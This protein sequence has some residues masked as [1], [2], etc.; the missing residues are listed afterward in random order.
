MSRL[1]SSPSPLPDLNIDPNSNLNVDLVPES[2]DYNP[3]Q[4]SHTT[5]SVSVNPK[6]VSSSGCDFCSDSDSNFHAYPL[7][8]HYP[9][10]HGDHEFHLG[11]LDVVTQYMDD[12]DSWGLEDN[13]NLDALSSYMELGSGFGVELGRDEVRADG[14]RVTG[15]DPELE[16]GSDL[17]IVEMGAGGDEPGSPRLWDSFIDNQMGLAN[18]NEEFEWEELDQ[19]INESENLIMACDRVEELSLSSSSISVAT[20]DGE[21]TEDEEMNIEWELSMAINNHNFSIEDS[22]MFDV[23]DD[24]TFLEQ[25]VDSDIHER[26][27]PPAAKRAVE[28]LPLVCLGKEDFVVCAICK[29]EVKEGEM[30]NKLPCCHYYH[31]ECI[32]PWLRIKN[33]CPVCRHELPT[34]DQDNESRN[35]RRRRLRGA[36]GISIDSTEG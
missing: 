18:P 29:D 28:N 4:P 3:L 25:L 12:L 5:F 21:L 35:S 22:Y 34:D 23:D 13:N 14:L 16:S 6:C 1:S 9:F 11:G 30:V 32:V 24:H 19:A 15:I 17:E 7:E 8:P 2:Q 10:S 31:G 26:G 27:S 20:E 36:G 33:T